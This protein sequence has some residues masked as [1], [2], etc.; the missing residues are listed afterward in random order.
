MPISNAGDLITNNPSR[1]FRLLDL[2]RELRDD[3]YRAMLRTDCTHQKGLLTT[4]DHSSYHIQTGILRANQQVYLEARRILY[5]EN[6]WII[7]RTSIRKLRYITKQQ[8]L[9]TACES[10]PPP[11]LQAVLEIKVDS[12]ELQER[13][14]R[15]T[16][17]L[18]PENLETFM[19][20]LWGLHSAVINGRP[21][22]PPRDISLRLDLRHHPR[23]SCE[24][25]RSMLLE[26]FRAIRGYGTVELSG[27]ID[28][29][30]RSELLAHM[31]HFP[32]K[33]ELLQNLEA[34]IKNGAIAYASKDYQKACLS[35]LK[36]KTYKE[37]CE[38]MILYRGGF[39]YITAESLHNHSCLSLRAFGQ[40]AIEIELNLVKVWIRLGL[41]W[42]EYRL[43]G[44]GRGSESD[45]MSPPQKA[46]MCLC[47]AILQL[48][49]PGQAI[50]ETSSQLISEATDLVR[51]NSE[52]LG[53]QL[54]DVTDLLS[55]YLERKGGNQYPCPQL[56]ALWTTFCY[57][58]RE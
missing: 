23:I 50:P 18:G 36:A 45:F 7:V 10:S 17:V 39:L 14:R 3:V 49:H 31:T 24:R 15:E 16:F 51:S 37:H 13:E 56:L 4:W 35:W 46:F 22:Y 19:F 9:H 40:S 29:S 34:F 8:I 20:R 30:Y 54:E 6:L 41:D 32:M 12:R 42:T 38:S 44:L 52:H 26:P 27:N 33:E 47:Q 43:A 58:E 11:S 5:G 21:F 53:N 55:S 2:P 25:L 1:M 57:K 48:Q 28:S